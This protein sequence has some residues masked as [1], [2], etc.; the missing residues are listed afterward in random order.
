MSASTA[1]LGIEIPSTD[2]LFVAIVAAVHI[3]L[4]IACVTAGAVAML[5]RKG[6]GRHSTAGKVYFW[7]LTALYASVAVLSAMRWQPNVHLFAIGTAAYASALFART[8]VR[9][10]WPNWGRLHIAGMGGSY[11]LLL[12]AFYVDN[13]KQLPIW[14]DLPPVTYW[15]LPLALGVPLIAWALLR[16]PLRGLGQARPLRSSAPR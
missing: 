1:I 7:C 13:G 4:G 11:V 10:R 6:R 15:L 8:A 3:P 2:P 5:S 14:K 16:H 9:M 12:I